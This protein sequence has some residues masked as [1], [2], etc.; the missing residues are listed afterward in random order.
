MRFL[1]SLLLLPYFLLA[2][3]TVPERTERIVIPGTSE[4]Y[5]QFIPAD[6][7]KDRLWPAIFVFDPGGNGANGISP[8][9]EVAGEFGYLVFASND[10]R[11]G[12]H[13]ENFDIAGRMIN[14]AISNY[15]IDAKRMYVAGFSGGSRLASAIAV[16]SKQMA[17]VIAC[18]SG[19]SPNVNEQPTQESFVYAGLVG[20]AD[21]NY[22]EMHAAH[23]WLNKFDVSNRMFV[24]EGEHRWPDPTT[25]KRAILWLE[26]GTEK[27]AKPE[28]LAAD[29]RYGDSLFKAGDFLMAH[30]E[31]KA[32]RDGKPTFAQR[33]YADS[34]LAVI[35]QK[36]DVMQQIREEDQLLAKENKLLNE[37]SERY[38]QDLKKA[39]KAS[40]KWWNKQIDGY[41]ITAVE[42]GPQGKQAARVIR[43][44]QAISLESGFVDQQHKDSY[45]KALFSSKLL[46]LTDPDR[47]YYHYLLVYTHEMGGK[48]DLALEQLED[49]FR[50]GALKAPEF[51]TYRLHQQLQGD[52]DYEDL[53]ARYSTD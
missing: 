21:M 28:W 11:N 26:M 16:L 31:F 49:S 8:F 14:G 4:S 27:N 5:L 36:D 44:I 37:L 6:Y 34:L 38:L 43:H 18:G 39:K 2:Q 45:D 19:F 7:D 30:K 40:F 25:I 13:S 10:A 22:A 9:L 12:R 51:T 17:G 1:V 29:R 42:D 50:S 3:Q 41:T 47:G 15:S 33:K 20:T 46:L 53:I 32:I 52:K 24:F 48:R 23:A 35:G